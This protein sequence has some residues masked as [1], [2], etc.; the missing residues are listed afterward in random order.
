[1]GILLHLVAKDVKRKARSPLG[2][3]A[4]LAFPL[5]FAGLIAVA[6]GRGDNAVPKVR[7]LVANE[8]DGLVAGLV[9]SAFT[10]Q[11]ASAY[12]DAKTVK[13]DE[14]RKLI[15]G[16]KA[17]ALLVI[18][19][20]FTDDVLD[21]KPVKLSLLR[22]P[23]EGILPEIAEQTTGAIADVL[24]AARRVFDK[25]IEELRP[26][27]ADDSRAPADADVI[28]ISL[29]V[30]KAIEGL[31][32]LIN[33][34]AIALESEMF[35]TAVKKEEKKSSGDTPSAIFLVVLPGV[36]V[37]GLFLVADQGMRDVMTERTLGTMRRQLAAP[38]S[39]NTVIVAKA[40]YTAL[41][42]A[43]ALVVMSVVGASVL[44]THVSV[45]GFLLLAFCLVLAVTGTAAVIYGLAKTERQA[46]TLGNMI[47]LMMGFLGGGFIRI[48]GL[49]AAVQKI[50]PLTPLYWG[51]QGFHALLEKG[52]GVAG[53][54]KPAL[55]LVVIGTVLLAAGGA[56]LRRTAKAGAGA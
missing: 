20:G 30:K 3:I 36:A 44:T 5:L 31:S 14:G 32:G 51:T 6:F 40:L 18:P 55:V 24:D 23:A 25:P 42:A 27:L 28:E 37:Y 48:E 13:A 38:V 43:A 49:P 9:A 1:M 15:D 10:S 17:S 2:L 46:A 26:L 29:S 34:P 45:A 35:G 16:G 4:A 39:A 19:K 53:V 56:A 33:P 41:L 21:K 12:F 8:D 50:A 11:Q 47:F 52:A 7:I 54:A 22:N